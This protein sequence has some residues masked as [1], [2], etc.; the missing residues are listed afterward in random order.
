MGSSPVAFKILFHFFFRLAS[1]FVFILYFVH[2]WIHL[3]EFG[4]RLCNK[5]DQTLL[6]TC[7]IG[8]HLQWVNNHYAKCKYK[9][10]QSV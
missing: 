9:G 1:F 5:Q 3:F 6:W 10:M 4:M 2:N 8:A 7:V